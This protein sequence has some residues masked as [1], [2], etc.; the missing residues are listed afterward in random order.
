MLVIALASLALGAPG[1]PDPPAPE[2]TADPAPGAAPDTEKSPSKAELSAP[3]GVLVSLRGVG[4]FWHDTAIAS[5]Y[6]GGGLVPGVGVVV[7]IS[8]RFAVDAGI[9]Y[10]RAAGSGEGG[11]QLVPMSLLFEL[12]LPPS[13]DSD[14][15]LFVGG[16]PAMMVW[17][18]SGQDPSF[19]AD[20]EG[21]PGPTVLRGARPGGE[22]RLGARI[23]L[24]LVESSMMP[25]QT[26]TLRGVH[27]EILGGRRFAPSASG[28]NFNTWRVGAGLA[29]LF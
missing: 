29:L 8:T 16:G 2:P 9:G 28:F 1:D 22:I 13:E 18:E 20:E 7:P 6:R 5:T 3:E 23:D 4:E 10:H 25:G 26:D 12:R 24:R 15:E 21:N 27:L 11:L 14:L 17:S 19:T